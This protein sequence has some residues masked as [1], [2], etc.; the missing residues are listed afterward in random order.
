M[1][2]VLRTFLLRLGFQAS[3]TFLLSSFDCLEPLYDYSLVILPSDAFALVSKDCAPSPDEV[4]LGGDPGTDL[5]A[6]GGPDS[7]FHLGVWAVG[8]C[9]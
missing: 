3:T 4:R 7:S 8:N 6:S 2:L 1:V 9:L 5:E